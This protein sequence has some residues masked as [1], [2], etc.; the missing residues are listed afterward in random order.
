M[1]PTS[2]LERFQLDLQ[3]LAELRVKGAERLV[4][5]QHGRLEDQGPRQGDALLLAARELRGLALLVARELDELERLA[6]ALRISRLRSFRAPEPEGD[7]VEDVQVR[8]EGVVLED[9]VDVALVRRRL[10]DVGAVQEDLAGGRLLEAGDHAQGRGL[11]AAG[12]PEQREE[13]AAGMWRLMPSTAVT[14]ANCLVSLLSLISPRAIGLPML[15]K[16]ERP[17][18]FLCRLPRAPLAAGEDAPGQEACGH[19]QERRPHHDRGDRVNRR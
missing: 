13:L 19:D 10:G 8:E 14:S 1:I 16:V 5:Q 11:P 3:R 6:D 15:G 4:E 12:R 17:A 7:V 18:E 2:L 9:A